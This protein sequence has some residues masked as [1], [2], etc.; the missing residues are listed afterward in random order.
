[1]QTELKSWKHKLLPGKGKME[2]CSK[3]WSFWMSL[4]KKN[5]GGGG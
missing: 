5:K 3:I 4:L 1:M 2:H